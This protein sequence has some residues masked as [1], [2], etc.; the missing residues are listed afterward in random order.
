MK[1][2]AG[3]SLDVT[4]H[5]HRDDVQTVGQLAYRDGVAYLQYDESFLKADLQISPIHH[6]TASGLHRSHMASEFEGLHGVFH[7]SLPDGWGRLLVDRRARQLGLDPASLTPL[8]RLAIVGSGG[9]GALCYAPAN[10]PWERGQ[11]AVDLDALANASRL[12]LRGD[13]GEVLSALGQ[14]GGSP[15]GAR[16]KALV[17]LDDRGQAVHGTDDVPGDH[18]HYVVKFSGRDDPP[19]MAA[20]EMAYAVMA[21]EAGV[22]MDPAQFIHGA[23]MGIHAQVDMTVIPVAMSNHGGGAFV[24]MGAV[25]G[26]LTAGIAP[27]FQAG[28]QA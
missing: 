12:V 27:R 5:W 13:V 3:A 25:G 14:T 8:D 22:A 16:P 7:D 17:A 4:L 26:L 9:I 10:M 2:A 11:G 15:G 23:V 1:L 19:D 24:E 20:I 21:V 28:E 18:A 6:Q